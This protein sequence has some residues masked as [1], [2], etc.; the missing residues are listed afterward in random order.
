MV[1]GAEPICLAGEQEAVLPSFIRSS[2][3]AEERGEGGAPSA[4]EAVDG[5]STTVG[6]EPVGRW[7]ATL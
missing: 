1:E 3:R 6:G 4:R 7:G 5:L 2:I